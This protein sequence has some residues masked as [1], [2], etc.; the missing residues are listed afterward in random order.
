VTC[1]DTAKPATAIAVNGPR[2]DDRFAGEIIATVPLIGAQAQQERRIFALTDAVAANSPVITGIRRGPGG[3]ADWLVSIMDV[4]VDTPF[5]DPKLRN[6][7]KFCN[8]IKYRFGITFDPMPQANWRAIV[9][10]AI[11]AKGGAS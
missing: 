6:Y 5:R 11:A 1:P 2:D 4:C 9:E 3:R 7:R 10:A 8:A